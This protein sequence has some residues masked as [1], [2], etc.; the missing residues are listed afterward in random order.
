MKRILTLVCAVIA[1]TGMMA[2]MH[3]AMNFVG[4]STM[5]VMTTNI[6]SPS[7]T[8]RFAMNGMTS[9]DITLPQM[10][11]MATIPS[12][13]I[14]DAQFAMGENHV[15][16][17][18]DQ[19]FSATVMVDGAEKQITGQSLT[20]EYNMADNSLT[21]TAVFKYGVMP[22]AM[23]YSVKSYYVKVVQNP[24]SVTV[25]GMYT[26]TNDNVT[27]NVRKYMD[28]GVEKV[29]VEVPEYSLQETV[30]GNLTLGKYVV[31][32]LTYDAEK[33]GYY[34]DYKDD[35]LSFHFTAESNG[36]KTMDGDYAF[37]SAKDNNIL[38]KYNGNQIESVVNT[39]QMGAMPF[40]IVSTFS[41]SV[42]GI[43]G[44]NASKQM[45]AD[46]KAYNLAG[47][48]VSDTAKG[49]VIINGKKYLR[50]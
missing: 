18:A 38:V 14:K 22:Y 13:T 3:G 19:T 41:S 11:G 28:D 21:L 39:F 48:R 20:G 40:P 12:F 47:Q 17:F 6:D 50:K 37:N 34:R 23:T 45:A 1:A 8:I 30:M 15:V 24:I 31:K 27:Y 4:G 33:D 25:G 7:D 49:I 5:T 16:T 44:V 10:K 32:G 46:G 2:Q 42:N 36:T 9:G 43:S 26:Y 35:A 29:D